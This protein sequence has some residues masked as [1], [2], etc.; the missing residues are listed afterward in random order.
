M[1]D[2]Y[3]VLDVARS[4]TEADIKASFRRLAKQ[5]HPDANASDP[6]VAARFA[7]LNSAYEILGDKQKRKAFDRGKIDA[8]GRLTRRGF[9]QAR[10][11]RPVATVVA[12]VLVFAAMLT[13]IIR[14][15]RPQSEVSATSDGREETL[16]RS[17]A[18]EDHVD[19]QRTEQVGRT[20]RSKPR[21]ALQQSDA[22]ASDIADGPA[23]NVMTNSPPT[24]QNAI[25]RATEATTNRGQIELLIRRSEQL[26]SEGDV[27]AG[28][29]M[30][31]PA[32]DAHDAR[33]ALALGATYD[34]I[35]LTILR[36]HGVAADVSLA[37]DWYKK[38]SEFGSQEAQERLG[39]L[40]SASVSGAEIARNVEPFN[41]KS[42]ATPRASNHPRMYMIRS[43]NRALMAPSDPNGV[44]VAGERVGADPDPNIRAQLV[45][46]DA[47]RELRTDTAG[48]QLLAEPLRPLSDIR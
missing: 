42:I 6:S 47:G 13:V 23:A 24:D 11:L 27:A 20:A 37:R 4:A 36:T 16:S 28:R 35:M 7:E 2:P 34:P 32:A 43:P 30:L 17:A 44:Y 12:M 41:E 14:G 22:S 21:I 19:A 26:I 3:E 45:R 9:A 31:Q 46:D 29:A 18:N 8:D 38:A 1:H 48:R 5:L 25:H 15:L 40:T 39:L 10:P 33:A